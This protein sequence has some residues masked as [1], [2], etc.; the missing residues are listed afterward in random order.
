MCDF[1][2][3]TLR[4]IISLRSKEKELIRMFEIVLGREKWTCLK[5][6]WKRTD[7]K[8]SQF[9]AACRTFRKL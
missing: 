9:N 3:C 7:E 5:K 6:E 4:Y 1:V 8:Y 2:Q